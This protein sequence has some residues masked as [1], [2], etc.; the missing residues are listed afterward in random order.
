MKNTLVKKKME[1]GYKEKKK[2]IL[3]M[4]RSPDTETRKV[5]TH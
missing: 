5:G 1:W 2:R 4:S 3:F